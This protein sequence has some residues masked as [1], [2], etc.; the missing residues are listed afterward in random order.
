MSVSVFWF[1]LVLRFRGMFYSLCVS[2]QGEVAEEGESHR[3]YYM[4]CRHTSP[5]IL[6]YGH[7]S[8]FFFFPVAP[9]SFLDSL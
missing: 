8:T 3:L 1:F 6:T 4:Y 9:E 2:Q 7:S 5:Y